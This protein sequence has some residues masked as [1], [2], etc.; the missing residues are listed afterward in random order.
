MDQELKAELLAMSEEEMKL[1]VASEILEIRSIA[2]ANHE[3]VSKIQNQTWKIR[4]ET[5]ILFMAKDL[6]QLIEKYVPIQELDE[7]IC[8]DPTTP[9]HDITGLKIRAVSQRIHQMLGSL[10]LESK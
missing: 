10:E 2:L 3:Q 1:F 7:K 5:N 4:R 8:Y 6:V 9:E